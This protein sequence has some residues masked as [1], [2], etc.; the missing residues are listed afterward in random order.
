MDLCPKRSTTYPTR[1]AGTLLGLVFLLLSISLH[2]SAHGDNAI[3]PVITPVS[4]AVQTKI[5][6]LT[7]GIV[8]S[9]DATA[10]ALASTTIKTAGTA[11]SPLS[12]SQLVK[13]RK[14]LM[15][16]AAKNDPHAFLQN[17]MPDDARA[18]LPNTLQDDIE[19]E[20][21]LTGILEIIHVD[22]FENSANSHYVFYL[23]TDTQSFNL[24]PSADDDLPS[25]GTKV[26][27][28]AYVLD[29]SAVPASA[30]AITP[31]TST[32]VRHPD[33]T[34]LQNLLIIP[35]Q[36]TDTPGDV[37]SL[38]PT[39]IS[40][41][42]FKGTFQSFFKQQSY[43]NITFAGTVL[44]WVKIASVEPPSNCQAATF[45][46]PEIIDAVSKA[47]IDLSQYSGVEFIIGGLAQGC[48][49]IGKDT[50]FFKGKMYNL[51]QSWTGSGRTRF[52]VLDG[53]TTPAWNGFLQDF[54]HEVGHTLGLYHS[55]GW[56]CGDKA[57]TGN[58]V[59]LEYGNGYDIMG[60]GSF[61]REFD[62]YD[63][64]FLGWLKGLGIQTVSTSGVYQLVPYENQTGV[65][66]IKITNPFLTA[67][68]VPDTTY[69]LEYR[70]SIGYD[71]TYSIHSPYW[72]INEDGPFVNMFIPDQHYTRFV[73]AQPTSAPWNSDILYASLSTTTPL[74]DTQRGISMIGIPSTTTPK[75]GA[76]SRTTIKITVAKPICTRAAPVVTG[77]PYDQNMK[78][79]PG[80][81]TS[82]VVDV[83]SN[84][85]LG[86]GVA[87]FTAT[88]SAPTGWT[89]SITSPF[90]IPD[91]S[92]LGYASITITPS[93]NA[94]RGTYPVTFIITDTKSKLS[95]SYTQ[96]F[97]V[98]PAPH[99]QKL[100]PNSGPVG[101]T[102]I[103]TGSG[104]SSTNTITIASPSFA[105]NTPYFGV[106]SLNGRT[107]SFVVPKTLYLGTKTIPGKYMVWV[108]PDD[109]NT[110]SN[111]VP[112]TVVT[113]TSSV[114]TEA[115]TS[116]SISLIA[117]TTSTTT[118]AF[119]A[120]TA[121][122]TLRTASTTYTTN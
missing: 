98:V 58:C 48:A 56:D 65:R 122:S 5:Q 41:F 99:I 6:D 70:Q 29:T 7:K 16:E 113:A 3:E 118:P 83:T 18:L 27:I 94:T 78:V 35:V 19:K 111:L 8:G 117:P 104:F 73:D 22:D 71:N 112:F 80:K 101:T 93:A 13:Q 69:Y 40:D 24:Y 62:A 87:T 31:L 26:S 119:T 120:D 14:A 4:D 43:G 42:L 63:K 49:A 38:T 46:T 121:S 88:T 108:S 82:L 50:I 79:T 103:I 67:L 114:V 91:S 90:S 107:L 84:D 11:T 72:P 2:A 116:P 45:A 44:P 115:T 68:G 97:T 109:T 59:H 102:V 10:A 81:P 17:A 52:T 60:N 54:T 33:T 55:N 92:T 75:T 64:E 74:V 36:Y 51:S 76:L 95:A 110:V 86:C 28:D 105:D 106:P 57:I 34:G 89:V 1:K 37:T 39:Q 100:S 85:S 47:G 77:N 15:L 20:I 21:T 61:A 25:P 30:T 12:Q 32:Q 23:Q 66:A 53:G 9:T 96:S